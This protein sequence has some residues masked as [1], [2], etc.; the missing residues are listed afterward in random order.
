MFESSVLSAI[1]I[2]VI[3]VSGICII[4][5]W[6]SRRKGCVAGSSPPVN[7]IDDIHKKYSKKINTFFEELKKEFENEIGQTA[8]TTENF[9]NFPQTPSQEEYLITRANEIMYEK[10][11]YDK[12]KKIEFDS[13][14]PESREASLSVPEEPENKGF[15]PIYTNNMDTGIA[16]NQENSYTVK[17]MDTFYSNLFSL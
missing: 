6:Y 9:K 12:N 14:L 16:D 2:W 1:A 11:P 7:F 8:T 13:V 4:S 15:D 3:F 17:P 10:I 5:E